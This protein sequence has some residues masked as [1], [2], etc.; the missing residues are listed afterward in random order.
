M[1]GKQKRK[2]VIP[3]HIQQLAWVGAIS[4]NNLKNVVR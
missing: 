1:K 3:S 2:E 4:Y